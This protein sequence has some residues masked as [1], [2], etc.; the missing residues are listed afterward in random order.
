M[1]SG[2][3]ATEVE[4]IYSLAESLTGS[5]QRAGMRKEILV[6]NVARRMQQLGMDDLRD[7]LELANES[8]QEFS[9]LVSALT[10]HTTSWFREKP[11]F[12]FL[13]DFATRFALRT[14]DTPGSRGTQGVLS[15]RG[16]VFRV[17]CAAC[18]TGEEVYSFAMVLEK[19]R[20]AH[21]SFEYEVLGSDIDPVSVRK[22]RTAIYDATGE[23]EFTG[24]VRAF[25]RLGSGPTHGK[26]TVAKSVRDRCRFEVRNLTNSADLAHVSPFH[27]V[28]CRN[29]LIY[30]DAAHVDE[31]VRGLMGSL[32]KNVGHLCLGHSESIT[33]A[34]FGLELAR[35]S[36]YRPSVREDAVE[37]GEAKKTVL[38][39]DDSMTIRSLASRVLTSAGYS[40]LTACDALAATA[41]L[42]DHT[43]DVITLD[44]NMPG[45][46]GL[47]WLAEQRRKGMRTPVIVLS[48]ANPEAAAAILASM[49]SGA[50]EFVEKGQISNDPQA[51][52]GLVAALVAPKIDPKAR[53]PKHG[54]LEKRTHARP[55]V[56]VI[57]ASTGG[58]EALTHLLIFRAMHLLWSWCSTFRPPFQRHFSRGSQRPLDSNAA[59]SPTEPCWLPGIC[60]CQQAISTS[61]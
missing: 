52:N 6:A 34:K 27:F 53:P 25:L 16:A 8:D 60:T 38:V 55:D 19:I 40:V 28:V 22:A 37:G 41:I 35:N 56:I 17:W 50:Q 23:R 44:V 10:I 9:R 18:S 21:P 1:Q 5:C 45:Q 31:I 33:P 29:V 13:R 47:D 24:S 46:N 39:V 3:S 4:L 11:H 14:L 61:R 12:E 26:L 54:Y 2:F 42:K 59:G 15:A 58:T 7:Y 48:D 51:L 36:I 43:V 49:Q 57:G 30:F 20:M 32:E